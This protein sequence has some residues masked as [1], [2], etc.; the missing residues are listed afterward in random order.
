MALYGDPIEK[1]VKANYIT[2]TEDTRMVRQRLGQL[3]TPMALS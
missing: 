2:G 1:H 3:M